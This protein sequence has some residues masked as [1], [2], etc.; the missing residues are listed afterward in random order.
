MVRVGGIARMP[1]RRLEPA[2]SSGPCRPLSSWLTPCPIVATTLIVVKQ[3]SLLLLG[4]AVLGREPLRASGGDRRRLALG[5]DGTLLADHGC[6]LT[7]HG[8]RLK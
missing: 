7:R 2:N 3:A 1:Q 6:I 4:L 5:F 8:I